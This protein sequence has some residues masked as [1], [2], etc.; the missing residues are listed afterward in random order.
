MKCAK[1]GYKMMEIPSRELRREHGKSGI[2]LW[3]TGWYYIGTIIKN[4]W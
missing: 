4:M 2:K 1:M 3:K